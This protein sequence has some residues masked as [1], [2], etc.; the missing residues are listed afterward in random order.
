MTRT[1]QMVGMA[2]VRKMISDTTMLGTK[3]IK[4]LM[5]MI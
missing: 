5:A 2:K 3:M 1:M 4:M